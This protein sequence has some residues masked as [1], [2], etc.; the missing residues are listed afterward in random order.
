[1]HTWNWAI[2][3][4]ACGTYVYM[5]LSLPGVTVPGTPGRENRSQAAAKGTSAVPGVRKCVTP[6]IQNR[7]QFV[8]IQ[9]IARQFHFQ[10]CHF[11]RSMAVN[12]NIHTSWPGKHDNGSQGNFA[13]KHLKFC[14]CHC[15]QVFCR[16]SG[17]TLCNLIQKSATHRFF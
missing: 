7:T 1:M 11:S 3:I 5:I 4:I 17:A 15:L 8:L 14:R 2:H 6:G 12:M 13:D 16:R 9:R 10:V